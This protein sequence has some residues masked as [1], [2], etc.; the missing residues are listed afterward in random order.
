[1]RLYKRKP[2]QVALIC[3]FVIACAF[4]P[5]PVTTR[6]KEAAIEKTINRIIT[7]SRMLVKVSDRWE[8]D[9]HPDVSHVEQFYIINHTEISNDVFTRNNI[10]TT[11]NEDY[12]PYK[13]GKW[14]G[15]FTLS[16]TSDFHEHDVGDLY[17]GVYYGPDASEGWRLR[18]YNTLFFTYVWYEHEW[19]A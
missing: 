13:D 5:L 9:P 10:L 12:R 3:I 17:F 11:T 4:V 6:A 16:H 19:V 7:G 18:I 1:M 15:L 8:N 2:F 14:C